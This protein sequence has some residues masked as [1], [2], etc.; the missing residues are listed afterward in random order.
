MGGVGELWRRV[1]DMAAQNDQGRFAIDILCS[2]DSCFKRIDV[3]ANLA[4]VFNVP[5]VGAET[6]C[7]VI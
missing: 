1:T 5:S 2:V 7:C 6:F 4:D 3:F